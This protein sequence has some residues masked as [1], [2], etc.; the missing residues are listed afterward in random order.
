MKTISLF[1]LALIFS[2]SLISQNTVNKD[3]KP[4]SHW[5][6]MMKDQSANFFETQK[7]FYSYTDGKEMSEVKGSKQFKRWEWFMKTRVD[8]NGNK[9]SPTKIINNYSEFLSKYGKPINNSDWKNLGPI[10]IPNNYI[11]SPSGLGRINAINY[12]PFN[13]NEFLIGSPSGGLW[14]TTDF[15]E[16]WACLSDEFPTLGVSAIAYDFENPLII[17][18]GTGDRD[19]AD[20]PG[21]GIMKSINGGE[22][23]EFSNEGLGRETVSK[24]M[25]NPYNTNIVYAATDAGFYKSI[26]KGENWERK[27]L[28][29]YFDFQLKPNDPETIYA[30]RYGLFSY[31]TDGGDNWQST[32]ILINGYRLLIGVSPANPNYVY[33]LTTNRITFKGLYFSSD[34]GESFELMSD[35]PN[36]MGRSTDGNDDDGQSWYDVCFTADRDEP[37]TI[38]AGGIQVWKSVDNGRNWQIIAHDKY[39]AVDNVHVDHHYLGYSPVNGNI[40]NGNDGGIYYSNNKGTNW[41]DI[42]GGLAISQI[43]KLGQSATVKDLIMCGYQDNSTTIYREDDFS[44]VIGADGMECI[45]DYTDTIYKYGSIQY[46]SLRRSSGPNQFRRIGGTNV[47]GITEDGNWVTP[48]SLHS[49][50]PNIMFAGYYNLWRSKNVKDPNFNVAWHRISYNLLNT[51][52]SF[53]V[54]IEQSPVNDDILYMSRED[55]KIFR[56]DNI[57]DDVPVWKSISSISNFY[58]ITDIEAHPYDENIVYITKANSLVYKSINK[59]D[60]WYNITYN[61]PNVNFNCLVYDK[62]STEGIYVG[63]D[64]GIYYKDAYMS[65]WELFGNEFP[66]SAEVTEVDIYYD[67]VNRNDS[68]LRASTFGRGLWSSPLYIQNLNDLTLD[69]AITS[70]ELPNNSHCFFDYTSALLTIKNSGNDTIQTINIQLLMNSDTVQEKLITEEL[71]PL[72]SIDIEFQQVSAT[73]GKHIF[74][75]NID[76]V[77]GEYDSELSNNKV[78][79]SLVV[80]NNNYLKLHFI[81]D[82][83]ASETSWAILQDGDTVYSSTE[84]FTDDEL[85]DTTFY[86][87][88]EA[89]CYTFYINDSGNDGI[90]CASGNGSVNVYN[91]SLDTL[92]GSFNS[93]TTIDSIEFC[94]NDIDLPV[95]DFISDLEQICIGEDIVIENTSSGDILSYDWNFGTDAEIITSEVS[96]HSVKYNSD[97]NKTVSLTV[98]SENG[99]VTLTK[100]NFIEVHPDIKIINQSNKNIEKCT[101]DSVLFFVTAEN[102]S[103]I[104]WF[105][106]NESIA[107]NVNTL[108]YEDLNENQSGNYY[109]VLKNECDSIVT[110]TI[111]LKVNAIPEVTISTEN[112]TFCEGDEVTLTASGAH[113][114]QWSTTTNNASQIIVSPEASKQYS[115]IGTDTI[116]GCKDVAYIALQLLYEPIINSNLVDSNYCINE[117]VVLY[118]GAQGNYMTYEW[119]KDNV[120]FEEINSPFYMIDNFNT[121]NS[122]NYKCRVYNSCGEVVSTEVEIGIQYLPIVDFTYTLNETVVSFSSI[123]ENAQNFYWAFG[124]D[125]FSDEENPIHDYLRTG[126]FNAI[127]RAINYCGNAEA[128]YTINIWPIGIDIIDDLSELIIYPNPND[129]KFEL[130]LNNFSKDV[131]IQIVSIIGERIFEQEIKTNSKTSV[132]PIQIENIAK[133]YYTL[134]VKDKKEYKATFI[135]K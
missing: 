127:H 44:T 116:T 29:D 79:D 95:P 68:R 121:E 129:G 28:G 133:G 19:H 125:S 134:I 124:D 119:S 20:A 80:N 31:S 108:L 111:V 13:E 23:W 105:K 113:S 21:L 1:I 41:S 63:T 90:C 33:I 135:V 10:E 40:F 54:D 98:S 70:F 16:T 109:C 11:S 22:S 88:L 3:L 120:V 122:G 89:G 104:D 100:E 38:Y 103:N 34:S 67:P 37:N 130:K 52:S 81:S 49:T 87:C 117:N 99:D 12:H 9:P 36:I 131:K 55:G 32:N 85:Y 8:E 112:T 101:G 73:H 77:N 78:S 106:D 57:N 69:A 43:Y 18:I 17:Y 72:S 25:V 132:I 76:K 50:N 93:Y 7:A 86:Y 74:E 65:E 61:L 47:N 59:G 2:I 97:G 51:N 128:N 64:A 39:D 126:S 53:I 5:V 46:G 42:S 75:A 56:S 48:F 115:V 94:I 102:Y 110:D 26:D 6:N 60:S 62:T 27:I 91:Y 58:E 24:I 84:A 14:K 82:N 92:F 45:V 96:Y 114:Y 15:G 30:S 118:V 4:D 107:T 66:V 123:N 35:T 71:L 83:K